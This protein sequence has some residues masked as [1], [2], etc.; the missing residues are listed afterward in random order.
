MDCAQDVDVE[1]S[2]KF[3]VCHILQADVASNAR[4]GKNHI[5]MS[6]FLLY[7]FHN[8]FHVTAL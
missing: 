7:D 3:I 6:F 5:Q 8:I 4:I 1:Y 2:V